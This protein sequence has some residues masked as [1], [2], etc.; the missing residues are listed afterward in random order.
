MTKS[1]KLQKEQT[2]QAQKNTHMHRCQW[3]YCLH[4]GFYHITWASILQLKGFKQ[5]LYRGLLYFI[6]REPNWR[7]KLAWKGRKC[8]DMFICKLHL[9][10]HLI[11]TQRVHLF[12]FKSEFNKPQAC[13]FAL[14]QWRAEN[15][16]PVLYLTLLPHMPAL[17]TRLLMQTTGHKRSRGFFV[18]F[19][20]WF[21]T[22]RMRNQVQNCCVSFLIFTPQD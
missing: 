18:T 6:K 12:W 22:H 5:F 2:S 3:F 10:A 1:V 4:L 8:A 14:H 19:K 17:F 16:S 9:V 7:G 13:W 21:L 20:R 15:A 11:F